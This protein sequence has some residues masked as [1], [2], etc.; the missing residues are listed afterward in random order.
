MEE[1]AYRAE[2]RG[3]QRKRICE[4]RERSSVDDE[5]EGRGTSVAETG[6]ER[7]GR[8]RTGVEEVVAKQVRLGLLEPDDT[9]EVSPVGEEALPAGRR[10]DADLCNES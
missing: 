5:E 9:N 8:E 7:K 10:V 1:G 6:R 3:V 2:V 4:S